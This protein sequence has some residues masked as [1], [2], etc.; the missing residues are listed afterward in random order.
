DIVQGVRVERAGRTTFVFATHN[1][2]E[3]V[4]L[5]DRVLVMSSAP[6][7]FLEEFRIDATRPRTLEDVLVTRVISEI[8]DLLISEVEEA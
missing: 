3:A 4:L 8:H 7:T 6:G 5:A 1:V 2:R